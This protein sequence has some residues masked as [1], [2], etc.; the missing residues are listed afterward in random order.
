MS[1]LKRLFL[2][3]CLVGAL[4]PKGHAQLSRYQPLKPGQ[5]VEFELVDREGVKRQI[6]DFRG[7]IVLVNFWA[8]WCPPCVRELPSLKN[9]AEIFPQDEFIILAVS[10]DQE[11]KQETA[12]KLFPKATQEAMPLFFDDSGQASSLLEV[13]GLP[14][15]VILD[16]KGRLIGRLSGATIWDH[17][18]VQTLIQNYIEGKTPQ[19]VSWWERL[20]QIFSFSKTK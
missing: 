9:L 15:T 18:E 17:H 14:T 7:R 19:P 10:K 16:R 20:K 5:P 2:I 8:S 6:S 12:K 11:G 4:G 1:F 13:K 3:L